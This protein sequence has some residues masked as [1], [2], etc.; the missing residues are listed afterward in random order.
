MESTFTT[1]DVSV[2]L[3]AVRDRIKSDYDLMGTGK[4][5]KACHILEAIAASFGFKTYR[6]MK[7]AIDD[8]QW[9]RYL[10]SPDE[11]DGPAVFASRLHDLRSDAA[12]DCMMIAG[13]YVSATCMLTTYLSH[14]VTQVLFRQTRA[15]V[16]LSITCH[17][18]DCMGLTDAMWLGR[19]IVLVNA[20]VSALFW[21][22]E[23]H[24]TPVTMGV[25]AQSL[26]MDEASALL[27]DCTSTLNAAQFGVCPPE[28]AVPLRDALEAERSSAAVWDRLFSRSASHIRL[29]VDN[30]IEAAYDRIGRFREVQSIP[31]GTMVPEDQR[32]MSMKAFKSPHWPLDVQIKDRNRF[33]D[34]FEKMYR[35]AR[36]ARLDMMTFEGADGTSQ[37]TMAPVAII[38]PDPEAVEKIIGLA[39]LGEEKSI[40]RGYGATILS[41]VMTTLI[42]IR[43]RM[44]RDLSKQDVIDAMVARWIARAATDPTAYPDMPSEI[45]AAL[46]AY[47]E[48]IGYKPHRPFDEQSDNLQTR[49][50]WIMQCLFFSPVARSMADGQNGYDMAAAEINRAYAASL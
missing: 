14:Q 15:Q 17:V 2:V 7:T 50:G 42:W 30:Q 32:R 4:E 24:S 18:I 12:D 31:E 47:L 3:S 45:T 25:L 38:R 37:A 10:I 41:N 26:T 46:A 49:H 43:A 28:I 19:G 34:R 13:L 21:R 22:A 6:G 40:W 23:R 11:F 33:P 9:P 1:H 27:A 48:A 8:G 44:D 35:T 20:I 29:L 36:R 16:N 39:F 5:L